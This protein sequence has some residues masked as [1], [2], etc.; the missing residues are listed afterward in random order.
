MTTI[1][2][3]ISKQVLALVHHTGNDEY[4]LQIELGNDNG[5]TITVRKGEPST[6]TLWEGNGEWCWFT[7]NHGWDTGERFRQWVADAFEP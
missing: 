5:I 2:M 3:D 6:V 1:T 7:T 4:C